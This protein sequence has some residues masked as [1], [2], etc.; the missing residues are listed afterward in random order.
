[1][2]DWTKAI[3]CTP[4]EAVGR[5]YGARPNWV[6]GYVSHS[7]ARYLHARTLDSGADMAVEIGTASGVSTA[8][9]CHALSLAS[10]AGLIGHGFEVRTYDL[11]ERFYADEARRTGDALREM[12]PA[13]LLSHVVFRSPVT[14][15]TI[16]GDLGP[17]AVDLMFVDANHRHPWP[18][19]DL[20]ATLDVLRP[21]AEVILHDI[22]LPTCKSDAADWG[23]KYV[24]DGLDVHKQVNEADSVP[25]IGSIWLPDDKEGVREQL[26]AIVHAHEWETSVSAAV[27][28]PLLG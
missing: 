1:M 19:L 13:E 18:A 11:H 2:V 24:F 7:D 6:T 27:T 10:R 26:L 21:R 25:N 14:A 5:L 22:N 4:E 8:V 28:T 9:L 17:D 15:A 16:A 20:L 23:A 12:L 3:G